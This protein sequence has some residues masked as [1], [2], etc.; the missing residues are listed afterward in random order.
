MPELP[1]AALHTE[2]NPRL[3]DNR[4]HPSRYLPKAG[5]CLLSEPPSLAFGDLPFPWSFST[6][7]HAFQVGVPNERA[8]FQTYLTAECEATWQ[9]LI[10][11][12]FF[13]T[14]DSR[15]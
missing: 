10:G 14:G 4:G 3:H 6:A 7:P 9:V 15:E 11:S 1:S 8:V 12:L 5:V 2:E 13:S